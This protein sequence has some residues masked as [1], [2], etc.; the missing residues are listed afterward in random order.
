MR[1]PPSGGTVTDMSIEMPDFEVN[2]RE[3]VRAFWGNRES[4]RIKQVE[5]DK[6]DP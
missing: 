6:A 1:G 4:A 2:I 3:A 5:S